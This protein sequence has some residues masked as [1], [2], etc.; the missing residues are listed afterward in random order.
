MYIHM[1]TLIRIHS[2]REF[3]RFGF[4]GP[5]RY[6]IPTPWL[7]SEYPVCAVCVCVWVYTHTCTYIHSH[8]TDNTPISSSV[9]NIPPR[10]ATSALIDQLDPPI[11]VPQR[12]MNK[13]DI[14]ERMCK[15]CS[16][17]VR[18]GVRWCSQLLFNVHTCTCMV[19]T[20]TVEMHSYSPQKMHMH[21]CM[22]AYATVQKILRP[23]R[24]CERILSREHRA[25][26]RLPPALLLTQRNQSPD[27]VRSRNLSESTLAR[28]AVTAA[29]SRKHRSIICVGAGLIQFVYGSHSMQRFALRF[30][31][32]CIHIP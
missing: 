2:F 26:C 32:R 9:K 20:T 30:G 29:V 11:L 21:S 16:E 8:R 6:L 22:R 17:R 13:I 25:G 23:G 12:W 27:V 31:T 18:K 5:S 24:Y 10:Q 28:D 3:H 7:T 14:H 15:P 1:C 4:F 19:L